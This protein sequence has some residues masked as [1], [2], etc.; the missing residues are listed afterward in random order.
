MQGQNILHR[1]VYSA[2]S[3]LIKPDVQKHPKYFILILF[4]FQI[5]NAGQ[6]LLMFHMESRSSNGHQSAFAPDHI[7][8]NIL[9]ISWAQCDVIWKVYPASSVHQTQQHT[10]ARR[11]IRVEKVLFSQKNFVGQIKEWNVFSLLAFRAEFSVS[12]SVLWCSL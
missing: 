11:R 4:H 8:I 7:S 1:C 9:H 3:F 2:V 6:S 10:N 5:N 12:H